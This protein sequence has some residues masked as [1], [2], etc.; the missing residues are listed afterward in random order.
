MDK[1]WGKRQKIII[2]REKCKKTKANERRYVDDGED[3]LREAQHRLV[4]VK[5]CREDIWREAQHRW[6]RGENCREDKWGERLYR[7][8][9]GWRCREDK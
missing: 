3:E 8:M 4:R 5:K 7:W 1:R 2:R 9:R 6:V